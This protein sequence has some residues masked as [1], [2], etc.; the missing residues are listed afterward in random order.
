MHVNELGY[1][2]RYNVVPRSDAIRYIVVHYTANGKPS[3]PNAAMNNCVYFNN[4]NRDASAHYFIDNSGV[5][6]FADP[7]V[8]SCWHVGDGHG[9]FGITNQ[10]SVG[11]EVVQDDDAP[12]SAVET[13]YLATLVAELMRRF[14][15]PAERVV[16]H[17]DAS[18]KACPYYYTPY[19]A[20]GDAAWKAL[21]TKITEGIE[22]DMTDEDRAMLKA[23]Y[24]AICLPH[25]ASGRG[26]E[27]PVVDRV[28]WMAAKQAAM[29]EDVAAIKKAV[30]SK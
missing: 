30:A 8:W 6:R 29:V 28:A 10:N 9:E 12:F 18:R 14:G 24:N 4:G 3:T 11:I 22:D 26:V 5:W 23:V 17:Y 19:G 7:D 13:G 25:D 20:G 2:P 27:S 1:G 15:V 21:R 16:R